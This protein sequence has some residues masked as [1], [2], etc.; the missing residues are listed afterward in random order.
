MVMKVWKP[1]W[2]EEVK[3]RDAEIERGEVQAVPYEEAMQ[4]A[5][6]ALK[7]VKKK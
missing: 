6:D 1:A 3:K 7:E 2:L 5:R 4:S